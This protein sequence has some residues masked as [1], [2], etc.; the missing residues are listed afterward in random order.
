MIY[1]N[2]EDLFNQLDKCSLLDDNC[3]IDS[4][5]QD[6]FDNIKPMNKLYIEMDCNQILIDKDSSKLLCDRGEERLGT[7]GKNNRIIISNSSNRITA[8]GDFNEII[9]RGHC[10]RIATNGSA[11]HIAT[12]GNKNDI[13]TSG[14]FSKVTTNGEFCKIA[15]IGSDSQVAANNKHSIIVNIGMDGM[16]KGI[17]GTWITLAEYGYDRET[18]EYLPICIKSFKVDGEKIKENTFYKLKNKRLVQVK[19]KEE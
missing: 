7:N 1:G 13:V 18:R 19:N 14:P 16:A 5:I 6:N 3:N 9:A 2:Y 17:K 12:I 11:N 10:H 15:M 4:I 8:N